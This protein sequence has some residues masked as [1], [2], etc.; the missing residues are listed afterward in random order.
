VKARHNR[1]SHG[2]VCDKDFEKILTDIQENPHTTMNQVSFRTRVGY[3]SVVVA[4]MIMVAEE[5]VIR[6]RSPIDKRTY[7]LAA[8]I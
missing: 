3:S 4:V 2:R 1:L 7:I 6:F 5:A 8:V